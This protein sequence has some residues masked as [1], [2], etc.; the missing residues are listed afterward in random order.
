MA[1]ASG[2]AG[3]VPRKETRTAKA[4]ADQSSLMGE[5]EVSMLLQSHEDAELEEAAVEQEKAASAKRRAELDDPLAGKVIFPLTH[6]RITRTQGTTLRLCFLAL[7]LTISMVRRRRVR[8]ATLHT[9]HLYPSILPHQ[10]IPSL[11]SLY[12]Q[13]FYR[14]GDVSPPF[15]PNGDLYFSADLCR[16]TLLD[17]P[18]SNDQ[19]QLSIRMSRPRDQTFRFIRENFQSIIDATLPETALALD[20]AAN[21]VNI[22]T[23]NAAIPCEVDLRLPYQYNGTLYISSNVADLVVQTPPGAFQSGKE[24]V[25][26][27][28]GHV[29][30]YAADSMHVDLTSIVGGRVS[31]S[32]ER[33]IVNL[34]DVYT[35]S[36]IDIGT[37]YRAECDLSLLNAT[38]PAFSSFNATDNSTSPTLSGFCTTRGGE[39]YITTSATRYPHASGAF[40][41]VNAS[42][43]SGVICATA[44]AR[45]ELFQD[46]SSCGL[47]E[48]G[49]AANSGTGSSQLSCSMIV[50]LCDSEFISDNATFVDGLTC[51]T[52]LGSVPVH[53]H[54]V[55]VT[56]GGVYA[57]LL[58]DQIVRAEGYA[59]SDGGAFSAGVS[60]DPAT[61]RVLQSIQ[62]WVDREPSY[63]AIVAI[64]LAQQN[65][66]RWLFATKDVYLQLE[67]HWLSAFSASMLNPRFREVPAR[68]NPGFCPVSVLQAAPA[69]Q[70]G[71][72]AGRGPGL[73][74]QESGKISEA[75]LGDIVQLVTE[76]SRRYVLGQKS[77]RSLKPS[78][79]TLCSW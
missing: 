9:S 38:S 34:R 6:M 61:R 21:S 24:V 67:P 59:V 8:C 37:R 7:L 46:S 47:P 60:L 35:D 36:S 5:L 26:G 30:V 76:A 2:E 31:V 28:T 65:A 51:G 18:K 10:V 48:Q 74:T 23:S 64:D 40:V 42:E 52:T 45:T 12:R 53:E 49:G 44:P 57:G 62:A 33:G 56:R 50:D 11:Y 66:G 75:I 78:L 15:D 55:S 68:F 69:S 43:P 58:N 3:D 1:A 79:G 22:S 39:V 17:T 63:D 70:Q 20:S 71:A 72:V 14:P 27:P 77:P 32:A 41:R 16:L 73:G 19:V 29:S 54:S 13:F 25:L 4:Y